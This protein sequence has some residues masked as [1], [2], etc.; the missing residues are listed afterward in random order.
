MALTITNFTAT[1]A[2][3]TIT[4][5]APVENAT[6]GT[7]AGNK[8]NY[9][10]FDSNSAY[11]S[12][13]TR[14]DDIILSTKQSFT[15]D[16]LN[17]DRVGLIKITFTPAPGETKPFQE[18]DSVLVVVTNIGTAA[19]PANPGLEVDPTVV[20]A[21][22]PDT[23]GTARIVRDVEDAIAYPILTEQVSA[24]PA[25]APMPVAGMPTG[26]A[27]SI[28]QIAAKAVTD[29]LGWRVNTSDPK[30]FVGALTQAFTLTEVEGHTEA[31]WV[32][33]T[34]AVQTDLGGG[35]TGAQASLYT[36]AKQA[37]DSS[38]PL[39]DGLYALDPEADPEYVKA[40]REMARS[41]MSEIVK[42][43]GAA[44]GPSVL[45]VDT[46]FKILL[47]QDTQAPNASVQPDPDKIGGTLGSI[48]DIY[49]IFFEDNPFSNSIEDEQ[50]ITNFRVISDY[51][52]SLA[53]SW[54]SNRKFFE[55]GP[56]TQQA[57]FGTQLVLISRQLS[58]IADT[59]NE[60]RFVLDSVFIGASER[61]TLLLSFPNNNPPSMF[62]EDILNEVVD[63]VSDEGPRLLRDGGRI[64][65]TNNILPVVD[66]LQ[67]LVEAAHDPTNIDQLP[68]GYKTV[69]VRN[70]LDDLADQ[71][72]ALFNL[73]QQV[74]QQI[75][76]PETGPLQLLSVFP[77][78]VPRN[79]SFMIMGAGFSPGATA[80]IKIPGPNN[81]GT[82]I[83]PLPVTFVNPNLLTAKAPPASGPQVV[84]P[85]SFPL[86]V[87]NPDGA[88][89]T[90]LFLPLT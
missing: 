70:A 23:G 27:A 42:E 58:V 32:P 28:G 63:F 16:V 4:F 72:Q 56:S 22:V 74:G 78:Q 36:R 81:V 37:L 15:V 41:Q 18:G 64:A 48:R 12:P 11:F 65:V 76:A 67:D 26:G 30:G 3:V 85:G 49:G 75:P 59:V 77:D 1:T 29:V 88:S 87:T 57:F 55:V 83:V 47:N 90:G 86:T 44:G 33:R 6:T 9:T 69:R 82:T 24:Q 5:S 68:D 31:T 71:L 73:S 38:L 43:L 21:T 61:Q 84:P 46:Y 25:A 52:T 66:T 13:P 54:I 2:S 20:A 60:V 35:I 62:L 39:L 79:S 45:R 34:Y 7:G 10:I 19:N 40:L 80:T 50:D 53:Q 17:T 14:L 8:A 51:M 89:A